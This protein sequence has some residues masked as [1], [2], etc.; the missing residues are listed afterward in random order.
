MLVNLLDALDLELVAAALCVEKTP[1]RQHKLT[2]KS[3]TSR[4]AHEKLMES[5]LVL[6]VGDLQLGVAVAAV[7]AAEGAHDDLLEVRDDR[8]EE[9]VFARN[10]SKCARKKHKQ[11]QRCLCVRTDVVRPFS[12]HSVHIDCAWMMPSSRRSTPSSS[13]TPE[14]P[15]CTSVPMSV[16]SIAAGWNT[17]GVGSG[18]G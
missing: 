14:G 15:S 12:S 13:S 4:T 9:A 11:R 6:V 16:Y 18:S 3:H 10:L 7:L 5:H 1:Q 2:K 8:R 17:G